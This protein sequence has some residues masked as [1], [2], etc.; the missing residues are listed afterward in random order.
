MIFSVHFA[1]STTKVHIGFPLLGLP[2][3]SI[4]IRNSPARLRAMTFSNCPSSQTS[5]ELLRTG[6]NSCGRRLGRLR[7]MATMLTGACQC[8]WKFC[9]ENGRAPRKRKMVFLF[10]TKRIPVWQACRISN[11]AQHRLEICRC[12]S[13]SFD[14]N[15]PCS[16]ISF[17]KLRCGL[18]VLLCPQLRLP[19]LGLTI[20]RPQGVG[21]DHFGANGVPAPPLGTFGPGGSAVKVKL[22]KFVVHKIDAGLVTSPVSQN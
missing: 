4:R 3:L 12:R 9:R 17:H 10:A 6:N 1:H 16:H 18:F 11:N 14:K 7:L 19:C 15:D 2:A 22:G 20:L 13:W 21:A 8:V 5:M